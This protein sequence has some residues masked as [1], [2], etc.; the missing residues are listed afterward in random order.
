MNIRLEIQVVPALL[1]A[2]AC[3][4]DPGLSGVAGA[5]PGLVGEVVPDPLEEREGPCP[6]S[7]WLAS[8]EEVASTPRT[9]EMAELLALEAG[10]RLTAD[11]AA[12][13]R[14]SADLE[15]ILTMDASL[16]ESYTIGDHDAQG[17][18]L[19]VD[20]ATRASME[21]GTYDA[22]DCLNEYYGLESVVY[23]SY[24]SSAW[25]TFSGR[26][27]MHL[28]A[29]EYEAL[30]GV[31]EVEFS[32]WIIGGSGPSRLYLVIEARAH[33]YL[34]LDTR[35]A[36]GSLDGVVYTYY[37]TTGAGEPILG[38]RFRDGDPEPDWIEMFYP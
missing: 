34:F 25:L 18:S 23:P 35:E 30:P 14:I 2:C 31:H 1:L 36:H 28:L 20:S 15:A 19:R 16:P 11:P 27:A 9:D 37:L 24:L 21:A 26:Y 29:E 13:G 33:H 6:G 32:G 17:F 38:G 8:P 5:P 7:R 3:T 10:Y 4:H 12:Y 22:W